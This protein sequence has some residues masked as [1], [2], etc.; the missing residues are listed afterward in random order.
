MLA[1]VVLR[2][3]LLMG[4]ADLAAAQGAPPTPPQPGPGFRL[5][6]RRDWDGFAPVSVFVYD[7]R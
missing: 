4:A 5:V 7:V 6:E 1:P 2:T 3:L